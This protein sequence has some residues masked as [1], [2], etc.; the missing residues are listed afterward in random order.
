MQNLK[1]FKNLYCNFIS[2]LG[3]Y[4]NIFETDENQILN[5]LSNEEIEILIE[6][7]VLKNKLAGVRELYLKV[8]KVG[9]ALKYLEKHNITGKEILSARQMATLTAGE[10]VGGRIIFDV[11][12][13]LD[14]AEGFLT[15]LADFTGQFEI[16]VMISLGRDIEEVGR[17]VNQYKMS[18]SELI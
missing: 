1:A 10:V 11:E 4:I 2:S 8:P 5:F 16:P 12:D 15:E 17:L 7:I 9:L 18:P 13:L 14:Y 3:K 6:H